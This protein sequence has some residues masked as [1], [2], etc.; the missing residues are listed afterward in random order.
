[1]SYSK[2]QLDV[3]Q[4][5]W[6]MRNILITYEYVAAITLKNVQNE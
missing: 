2:H 5:N 6:I 3:E 4:Q 1:M